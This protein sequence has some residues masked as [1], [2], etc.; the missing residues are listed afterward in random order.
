MLDLPGL[1]LRHRERVEMGCRAKFQSVW[2][3]KVRE[4]FLEEAVR[5]PGRVG[6]FGQIGS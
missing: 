5:I 6:H 2:F 3:V 1:G 4:N